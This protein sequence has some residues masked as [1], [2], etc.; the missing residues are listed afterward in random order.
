MKK[1]IAIH[2][3]GLMFIGIVWT[4]LN[5]Y[6]YKSSA[7]TV[8]IPAIRNPARQ[9][10]DAPSIEAEAYY[11]TSYSWDTSYDADGGLLLLGM[12]VAYVIIYWSVKTIWFN[13]D[14]D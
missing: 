3:L 14:K 1:I 4:I 6:L 2:T 5:T 13:K 10:T 11:K 12:L 9:R 7:Y 8:H